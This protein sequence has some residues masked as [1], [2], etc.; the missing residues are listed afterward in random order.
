MKKRILTVVVIMV[1]LLGCV[2]VA[3]PCAVLAKEVSL[4]DSAKKFDDITAD[5]WYKDYVDYVVTYGIFNG[6]SEKAF[7][8]NGEITRAQFVQVLANLE[9]IDTSDKNV[10]IKFTDVPKGKWFTPAVK[11]ASENGVVN[12]VGDGKFAPESAVT[13]EQICALI[14]RFAG[15]KSVKLNL[16][17]KKAAFVDDKSIGSWAKE[18]V[19]TCQMAGIVNGKPGGKFDP[20]STATRAEGAKI[21]TTFHSDHLTKSE[22]EGIVLPNFVNKSEADALAQ[23]A[24]LGLNSEVEYEYSDVTSKNHV[25]RQSIPAG[26][27]LDKGDTVKLTVSLGENPDGDKDIIVNP[28]GFTPDSANS[29]KDSALRASQLSKYDFNDPP[30]IDRYRLPNNTYLPSFAMDDTGFVREGTKLSDLQ[31]KTLTFF[32]SEANPIWSYRDSKGKVIDEWTWFAELKNELGVNIKYQVKQGRNAGKSCDIIY[33]AGATFHNSICISKSLT[34]L[35]NIND[36]GS[37]PG[38]CKKTMDICKWGNSYRVISPVG[39]VDVLWYNQTLTQQL[40]LSDP[41]TMWKNGVWDWNAFSSFVRSVPESKSDVGKLTALV[42]NPADAADI[43]PSTNGMHYISID[44][45]NKYPAFINGWEDPKTVEAWEFITDVSNSVNYG[46]DEQSYLGLYEGKTVMTGTM[47]NQIYRDTEYSKNVQ[48][49]WVPY[50]K[51]TSDSGADV[52]QYSGYG[53][54]LPKKTVNEKNIPYALK[55]MELWATRFTETIF[56]N[57]NT[58]EYYN[59]NYKQRKEYYD[60]V[61]KNVVFALPMNDFADS[62]V[63]EVSDF[64]D[65]FKGDSDFKVKEEAEKASILVRAFI[66]ESIRYGQ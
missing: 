44:A 61:T 63:S 59:F 21:L 17:N 16:I 66:T 40:G 32:T 42:Q 29:V 62:Q 2:T 22:P 47:Y 64:F 1:L 5:K 58:F 53:M 24:S 39:A 54:M 9:N 25:I 31:N 60:F 55:F 38:I 6:T 23:L 51:S 57:L 34:D 14:V 8:P 48:I 10:K 50:P 46:F 4:I 12:G 13:R 36:E 7:T 35:I 41:H 26:T 18:D 28:N 33:T 27:K 3:A 30:F 20:K 37:S 19:Y 65:C 56:D 49:S 52:C 15:Y 45:D 43:W 11:W